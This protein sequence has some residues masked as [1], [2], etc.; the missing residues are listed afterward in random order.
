M[1]GFISIFILNLVVIMSNFSLYGT[2]VLVGLYYLKIHDLFMNLNKYPCNFDLLKNFKMSF[3]MS[4]ILL[5]LAN[6]RYN[7]CTISDTKFI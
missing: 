4:F 1:T 6:F 7:K 3:K 2:E 5:I